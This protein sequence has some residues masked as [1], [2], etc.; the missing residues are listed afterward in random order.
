MGR[1]AYRPTN[2]S[3]RFTISVAFL[4]GPY[5]EQMAE[6]VRRCVVEELLAMGAEITAVRVELSGQIS[7]W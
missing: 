4:I 3:Q 5:E 7:A 1:D 2:T 6:R